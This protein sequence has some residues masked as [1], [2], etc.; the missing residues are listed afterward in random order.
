MQQGKSTLLFKS[1]LHR[2]ITKPSLP[3]LYRCILLSNYP[4]KLLIKFHRSIV[5][6]RPMLSDALCSSKAVIM[7]DVTY[8]NG[9]NFVKRM[10]IVWRE[11]YLKQ[12]K[13]TKSWIHR[14]SLLHLS[15]HINA[16][17]FI[18]F[19]T[20]NNGKLYDS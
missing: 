13:Q 16:E 10:G 18:I 19:I 2:L 9:V 14:Y 3:T 12:R 20:N 6:F 8:D 7:E 4:T 15:A 1:F 11:T 17:R 5:N